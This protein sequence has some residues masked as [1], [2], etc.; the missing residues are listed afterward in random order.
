LRRGDISSR[1]KLGEQERET[2]PGGVNAI[3]G[4]RYPIPSWER[5]PLGCGSPI[6][7]IPFGMGTTEYPMTG[8]PA[9]T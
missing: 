4:R 1:L 2:D 7:A 6:N 9:G 8:T 5:D 3:S